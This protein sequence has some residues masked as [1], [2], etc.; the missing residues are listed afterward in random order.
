MRTVKS[1]T[2]SATPLGFAVRTFLT[3]LCGQES[4]T[5]AHL[6]PLGYVAA[7]QQ[8]HVNVISKLIYAKIQLVGSRLS[9]SS[10]T[11]CGLENPLSMMCG[12]ATFHFSEPT[13]LET[14][15]AANQRKAVCESQ[16]GR[17]SQSMPL[18]S[19]GGAHAPHCTCMS[20]RCKLPD[21]F[22]RRADRSVD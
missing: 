22:H 16:S 19:L 20:F 17:T 18:P 14:D 11:S 5:E 1:P 15:P 21:V 12:P 3:G 10:F 7:Y 6:R 8:N 4:L 2:N 13:V 9:T